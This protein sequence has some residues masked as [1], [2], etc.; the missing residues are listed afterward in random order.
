MVY[1]KLVKVTIYTSGLAEVIIN[2]IVW[3]H[4]LLDS[5]ISDCRVIFTSKF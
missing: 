1:Y 3:Y 2:M 5:I 4:G